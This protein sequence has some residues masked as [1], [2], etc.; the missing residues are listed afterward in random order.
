ME[1]RK[2]TLS[3]IGTK[4]PEPPSEGRWFTVFGDAD[5]HLRLTTLLAEELGAPGD[6]ATAQCLAPKSSWSQRREALRGLLSKCRPRA[7]DQFVAVIEDPDLLF[8]EITP[9]IAWDDRGFTKERNDL[10]RLLLNAAE[11]GGWV[12]LRTVPHKAASIQ[13]EGVGEEKAEPTEGAAEK[14]ADALACLS[15]SIRPLCQALEKSGRIS[16]ARAAQVIQAAKEDPDL[17]IIATAYDALAPSVRAVAKR[18]SLVRPAQM[19]NG[20]LGLFCLVHGEPDPEKRQQLPR[21]AIDALRKAA[22]LQAGPTPNTLRMPSP[23]RRFL[24]QRASWAW[25][26]GIQEAHHW[27]AK[28]AW[29]LSSQ[30]NAESTEDLVETHFHAIAAG[31]ADLACATAKYYGADLRE[32]AYQRSRKGNYDEAARLY[33]KIIDTF[34]GQDAY[35]WEYYAYNL[36]RA[37]GK[38]LTSSEAETIEDAYKRAADLAQPNP[39]FLGRYVGFKARLGKDVSEE[40]VA[41]LRSYQAAHDPVAMSFFGK[42]VLEG[43]KAARK[44]ALAKSL[45]K[46]WPAIGS[47]K[48]P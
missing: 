29:H 2:T 39:L 41:S 25:P 28:R 45:M 12:F 36:A 4:V 21:S 34:D 27:L 16:E 17:E 32:L 18:L 11:M 42:A 30:G 20:S 15:P 9:E 37:C 1:K 23:V 46:R 19:L 35:A 6:D 24:H 8:S 14:Y 13:F 40:A 26:T 38:T 31:D 22:F 10:F 47:Y 7:A 5:D 43:L 33:K 44:D 48:A 3:I